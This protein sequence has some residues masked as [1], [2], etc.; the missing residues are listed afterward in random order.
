M[1]STLALG[2]F[3]QDK[4]YLIK[5]NEVVAKY[6]VDE[7]DYMSFELPEGVTD[8]TGDTPSLQK[9]KYMSAVGLYFGTTDE[10][11]D[12]Q[13]QLSTRTIT[14]E[15]TPVSFLYLQFMGPAADYHNL[16]VPEGTYSVQNG[17]IRTPFTYYKGIRNVT[18][19]GEEVGG[20]IIV[21]RP[22]NSS[23]ITALVES[24][25]FTVTKDGN[26]YTMTGLF[27]LDNGEV[28]DFTY[29]GPCVID[30]KSDEKDPAETVPVP[31][32]SLTEDFTLEVAE[33]YYGTYGAMFA[34][35]TELTYN[36]IYLY[37]S[38]YS[39]IIEAGF[40]VDTTVNGSTFLPK[41]TYEVVALGSSGF[42]TLDKGALA[43]FQIQGD[44]NIAQ[45]GCW[46]TKDYKMSPLV[47]G[48][49]EVLEDFNGQGELKVKVTLTDNSATP[50]TVTATYSGRPEKL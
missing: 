8:N 34:D 3:A 26:D 28:L 22:D 30:N 2:S 49:I 7:V 31:E 12:Y 47:A 39:N 25:D 37:D 50:H 36:Y 45:Y 48:E 43:A 38:S 21:E 6:N 41:G 1:A 46:V 29:T 13:I 20:T 27:K 10:V 19:E 44:M 42:N 14:D 32:S 40:F 24:G 16:S 5:G 18:L 23:V 17:N 33:S 15:N 9:Q 35:K 11:A 4:L